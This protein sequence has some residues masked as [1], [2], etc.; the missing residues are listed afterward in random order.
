M[1]Q[2]SGVKKPKY[3]IVDYDARGT[4]RIYYRAPGKKKI[5]LRGPLFED[6]FWSDYQAAKQGKLKPKEKKTKSKK[7]KRR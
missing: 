5:R 2:R 6:D 4:P 7:Q 3:V 1:G